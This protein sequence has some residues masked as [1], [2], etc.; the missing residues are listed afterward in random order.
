[1]QLICLFGCVL[2]RLCVCGSPF[3]TGVGI[4]DGGGDWS[5]V[6]LHFGRRN[7]LLQGSHTRTREAGEMLLKTVQVFPCFAM[8]NKT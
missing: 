3:R 5:T 4:G 6:V 7:L 8:D 1:M 2:Q